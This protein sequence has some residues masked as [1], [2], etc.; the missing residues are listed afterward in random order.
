MAGSSPY[1]RPVGRPPRRS[2]PGRRRVS[3]ARPC[4]APTHAGCGDAGA[5]G[6]RVPRDRARR[7]SASAPG[8]LRPAPRRA[9]SRH[10]AP[11]GARVPDRRQQG[12]YGVEGPAIEVRIAGREGEEVQVRI[13]HAWQHGGAATVDATYGAAGQ[14][15]QHARIVQPD[16]AS[17]AHGHRVRVRQRRVAGHDPPALQNPGRP[18]Q[19]DDGSGFASLSFISLS[20]HVSSPVPGLLHSTSDTAGVAEV[21]LAELSRHAGGVAERPPGA[22]A[23]PPG[24]G[25]QSGGDRHARGHVATRATVTPCPPRTASVGPRIPVLATHEAE[26]GGRRRRRRRAPRW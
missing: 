3:R 22:Q 18:R 4:S 20:Q 13:D 21:P 15:P 23:H 9:P 10:A 26:R 24:P 1:T 8:S 6:R 12:R 11:P 2:T 19:S 17:T 16:D 5:P 25:R 7:P 14:P